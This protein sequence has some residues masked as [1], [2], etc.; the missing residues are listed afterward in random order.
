MAQHLTKLRNLSLMVALLLGIA[1]AGL[2]ESITIAIPP[3]AAHAQIAVKVTVGLTSTKKLRSADLRAARKKMID[4][5][6]L[7]PETL[8]ALAEKWDGLAAQKYVRFL[9]A[10]V[11]P[12]T[13]SDIAYFGTIAV[14][15]GRVWSLPEV[16][17]ALNKL[18]P[19][20]EPPERMKAYVAMLYPYAWAGNSL[21]VDALFDLNG[22]GKLFGEM[23]D[24]TLKKL[25]D[26]ANKDTEGRIALRLALMLMQ[27]PERS[28]DEKARA[29]HFL[30]M[31]EAS[32]NL[33]IKTT[34]VNL[35]GLLATG[36]TLAAPK[37]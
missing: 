26:Q 9:T 27:K 12:A 23:S 19:S 20:T 33:M 32:A 36:G 1:G 22:P 31:A 30:S 17:E 4:G 24:A 8:R 35:R 13:P 6:E 15:T 7:P 29:E 34:A 28:A 25:S 21:A 2:A 18:D 10:Q 37:A 11:P 5:E 16:V 14:S 3:D